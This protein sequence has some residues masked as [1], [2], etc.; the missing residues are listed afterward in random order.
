MDLN[1]LQLKNRL[2]TATSCLIGDDGATY[3]HKV[4]IS[5]KSPIRADAQRLIDLA[6]GLGEKHLYYPEVKSSYMQDVTTFA[7]NIVYEV[8]SNA[9]TYEQGSKELK[10]EEKTLFEQSLDIISR[11]LSIF[12]GALQIKAGFVLCFGS[13]G[14]ACVVGTPLILHG[15]NSIEEGVYG[16]DHVGFARQGY[17]YLVQ[18]MG[19]SETIG[20][21][22]YYTVDIGTSMYGL[23][24]L[25]LKPE[26]WK[27]FRY[28]VKDFE[29]AF[30]QMTKFGLS[31]EVVGDTISLYKIYDSLTV[32]KNNNESES[33][34]VVPNAPSEIK[35][36]SDL[37]KF[38]SCKYV[39]EVLNGESYEYYDCSN[40]K[41]DI[42]VVTPD[43]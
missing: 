25:E 28:L 17:R 30:R 13:G 24:K 33:A 39:K 31:T 16:Q 19:Y 15:M 38:P 14:L 43:D 8:E 35:S 36:V 27:L 7:N 26:A 40:Q 3:V 41:E 29:R 4:V 6:Y 11:G 32:I 42:M 1:E 10:K 34:I 21:T 37:I 20:D 5:R 18:S 9:K 2:T 12:L 22:I 23:F